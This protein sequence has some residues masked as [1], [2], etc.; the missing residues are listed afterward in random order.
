MVGDGLEGLEPITESLGLVSNRICSDQSQSPDYTCFR[1]SKHGCMASKLVNF[2]HLL[3]C[4]FP[5]AG[6]YEFLFDV[7]MKKESTFTHEVNSPCYFYI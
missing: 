3:W 5:L 1:D 7:L 4:V 6:K 2:W